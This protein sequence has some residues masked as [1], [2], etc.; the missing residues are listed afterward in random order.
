MVP[1]P[2]KGPFTVDT[3]QRLEQ[4]GVLHDD[5]RVEL[6]D[7]Q[8]VEMSLISVAHA[9]CVDRLTRIFSQ[10]A[11]DRVIVRTDTATASHSLGAPPHNHC[12]SK[13]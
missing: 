5:D 9:A 6:I 10:R 11:A 8:V 7:G 4:L 12:R 13:A 1:Q 2:L 3:Y